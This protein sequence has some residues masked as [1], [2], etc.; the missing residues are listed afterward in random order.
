MYRKISCPALFIHGDNDQIQPHER[1]KAAHAEVPGAEFATFEGG[2]HNPLGRYPAK[3]NALINDFLDRRL[4]IAAPAR[5]PPRRKPEK[6]ALY[7]SSPIGLGHARRDIAITRELRKLH[8]D[9]QVDWLAQ[10]PVTRLLES[11]T[12][13]SIR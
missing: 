2:G 8:P 12:S 6:R 4:G 13:T 11:A 10:D 9:L 1:A 5:E 7:L 3:S